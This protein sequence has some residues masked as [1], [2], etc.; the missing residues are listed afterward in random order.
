MR[1][2]ISIGI[3]VINGTY[4]MIFEK[5]DQKATSEDT[6]KAFTKLKKT[7]FNGVS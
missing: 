7:Q 4:T 3:K 1:E 6:E 2:E 5:A